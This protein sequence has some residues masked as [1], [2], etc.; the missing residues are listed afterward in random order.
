MS[1]DP[2]PCQWCLQHVIPDEGRLIGNNYWHE[3]CIPEFALTTVLDC[4]RDC[5]EDLPGWLNYLAEEFAFS[6]EPS[7]GCA[8]KRNSPICTDHTTTTEL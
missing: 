7:P 6:H 3:N 4:V 8:T 1:W 5:P 2:T